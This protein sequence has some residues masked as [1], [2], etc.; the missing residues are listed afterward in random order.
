M[1]NAVVVGKMRAGEKKQLIFLA[2]F[3][4]RSTMFRSLR[5]NNTRVY[6]D[7]NLTRF[8]G[9][10]SLTDTVR[11]ARIFPLNRRTKCI[12]RP[13]M[14]LMVGIHIPFKVIPRSVARTVNVDTNIG[15]VHH[16]RG[17]ILEVNDTMK[18]VSDVSVRRFEDSIVSR[19]K[20]RYRKVGET[21]KRSKTKPP[22]IIV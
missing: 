22:V 12:A 5:L 15:L 20:V 8:L 3:I 4:F 11:E 18:S 10:R 13:E 6:T 19:T 21:S 2:P 14:F 1:L 17:T 7:N 16:Y 9:L